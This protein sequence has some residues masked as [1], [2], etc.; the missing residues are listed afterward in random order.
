VFGWGATVMFWESGL[1]R[2]FARRLRWV[3]APLSLFIG[4]LLV[5]RGWSH[6]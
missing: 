4:L 6:F 1:R 5:Y 3:L 2:S